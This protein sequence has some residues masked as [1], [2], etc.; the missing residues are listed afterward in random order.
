MTPHDITGIF[1]VAW[2]GS[3]ALGFVLARKVPPR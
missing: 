2:L 1:I 3:V